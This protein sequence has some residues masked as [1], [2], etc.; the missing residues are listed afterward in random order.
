MSPKKQHVCD[1]WTKTETSYEKMT[2]FQLL[3]W[4]MMMMTNA[5]RLAAL[6]PLRETTSSINTVTTLRF[7]SQGYQHLRRPESRQR[8]PATTEVTCS[9]R[10]W[11]RPGCFSSSSLWTS[12]TRCR[13]SRRW[14]T[15][16]PDTWCPADSTQ[17][18]QVRFSLSHVFFS[19]NVFW[20]FRIFLTKIFL[21]P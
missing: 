20:I 5:P 14:R 12:D 8:G 16:S 13:D 10:R 15:D 21:C 7:F 3:N 6:Q 11:G 19:I 9:W 17:S 4:L 2:F 18:R 1:H